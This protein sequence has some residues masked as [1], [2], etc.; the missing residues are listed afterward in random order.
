MNLRDQRG[1]TGI[2]IT[3]SVILITILISLITVLSYNIQKSSQDVQRRTE[4]TSYAVEVLERVK[5]EGFDILPKAGNG[6]TIDDERFE[7]KYIVDASGE[8]TG[9]YQEVRV[10]D[11]SEL[12]GDEGSQ[13]VPDL[14]KRVT[15]TISYKSGTDTKTVE[16][17]T[18]MSKES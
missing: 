5:S 4:A 16:L 1:V 17:S 18:L 6:N 11:Y 9:F 3:I 7:D 12:R 14:L 2:D 13:K 15:V 8:P 10:E